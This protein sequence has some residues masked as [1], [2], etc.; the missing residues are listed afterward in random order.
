MFAS[1]QFLKIF[2]LVFL[3]HLD[4]LYG[5]LLSLTI[6]LEPL[7]FSSAWTKKAATNRSK[8]RKRNIPVALGTGAKYFV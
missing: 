1:G 3:A 4:V 8:R 2:V 7:P 5:A 6:Q